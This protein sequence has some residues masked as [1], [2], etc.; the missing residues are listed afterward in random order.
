MF[1]PWLFCPSDNF[2]HCLVLLKCGRASVRALFY[3]YLFC[4]PRRCDNSRKERA[5]R[6]VSASGAPHIVTWTRPTWLKH[7]NTKYSCYKKSP[8]LTPSEF[9]SSC[10]STQRR[11]FQIRSFKRK[12]SK[13]FQGIV[14][15]IKCRKTVSLK[16]IYT[17]ILKTWKITSLL[18]QI[19][20]VSTVEEK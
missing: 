17:Y 4:D 1:C 10:I 3:W 11:Q 7:H 12:K 14:W 20:T 19:Y 15:W 5:P 13:M 18:Y 9:A 16:Q 8:N 6:R 2:E